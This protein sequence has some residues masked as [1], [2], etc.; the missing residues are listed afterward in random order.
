MEKKG[1]SST[2]QTMVAAKCSV[3]LIC[4]QNKSVGC[5]LSNLQLSFG[6]FFELERL[7]WRL[8]DWH[9]NVHRLVLAQLIV[10]FNIERDVP[11]EGGQN[12]IRFFNLLA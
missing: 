1:G 6:A 12:I 9:K 8:I 2:A 3:A 5:P 4:L 7:W 10:G 11:P